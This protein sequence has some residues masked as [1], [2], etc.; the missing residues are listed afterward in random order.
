MNV[1]SGGRPVAYGHNGFRRQPPSIVNDALSRD[2][3]H[4]LVEIPLY[5]MGL[6]FCAPGPGAL[7]APN[8]AGIR[9]HPQTPLG[10]T[11]LAAVLFLDYLGRH[12]R[13]CY[14]A[15]SRPA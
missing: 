3:M 14:H 11:R 4:I 9:V 6:R 15:L 8:P 5:A 2:Q 7:I 12:I 1:A 10:P 13:S